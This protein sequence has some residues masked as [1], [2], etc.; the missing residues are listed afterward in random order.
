[1]GKGKSRVESSRAASEKR[2]EEERGGPEISADV[3]VTAF[4]QHVFMPDGSNIWRLTLDE[5][6]ENGFDPESYKVAFAHVEEVDKEVYI[7]AIFVCDGLLRP[8]EFRVTSTIRPNNIQNLLYGKEL[9]PFICQELVLINCLE[10][11]K[12]QPAVVLC[13]SE[14]FLG[15]RK[16]INYSLMAVYQQGDIVASGSSETGK[17]QSIES[18]RF[19]PLVVR[20]APGYDADADKISPL[21][22]IY[23]SRDLS[24]P[25]ERLKKAIKEYHQRKGSH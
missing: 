5:Q 14:D 8:L 15:A 20:T 23:G 3:I 18:H 22:Q 16:K 21:Q 17:A 10:K 7:G 1:M 12:E 6:H 24:E 13:S 11:L 9:F 4:R 19:T 2:G 25:F